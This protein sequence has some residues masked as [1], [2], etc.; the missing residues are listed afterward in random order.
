[1]FDQPTNCAVEIMCWG[2]IVGLVAHEIIIVCNAYAMALPIPYFTP[3][4]V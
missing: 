1:M 4:P 3:A 2:P